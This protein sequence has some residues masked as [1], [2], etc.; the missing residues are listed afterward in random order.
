MAKKF[1]ALNE[2]F[3]ISSESVS[4][5]IEKTEEAPI[6]K[7]DQSI[8]DLEKDYVYARSTMTSIIDKGREALDNILELAQETDSARAYEVVGQLLDKVTTST[9]KLLDLHKKMKEIKDNDS[10]NGPTNVTNNAIFF[11]S[12]S[13]AIKMIKQQLKNVDLEESSDK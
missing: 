12:T 6:Q 5:E 10:N 4:V 3:N 8:V 11:G 9:E 13:E 2:T 7:V 1:D